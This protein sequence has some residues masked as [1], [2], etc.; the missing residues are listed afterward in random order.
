[1]GQTNE[2]NLQKTG[3]VKGDGCLRSNVQ[4]KKKGLKRDLKR[5]DF[6]LELLHNTKCGPARGD[7]RQ[8]EGKKRKG[9]KKRKRPPQKLS[10]GKRM[11]NVPG[12]INCTN[13]NKSGEKKG[14]N[15][16]GNRSVGQDNTG[17]TTAALNRERR[18]RERA[19]E[20]HQ[21]RP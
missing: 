11:V 10:E 5:R 21:L 19:G 14:G 13:K 1:V 17:S 4:K 9:G 3:I 8:R 20:Q 7:Y 16:L 18:N 6:K 15:G 2:P 12:G